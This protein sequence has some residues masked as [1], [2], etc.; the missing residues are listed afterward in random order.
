MSME[1]YERFLNL[2]AHYRPVCLE[3]S[4]DTAYMH[5][6]CSDRSVLPHPPGTL[7]LVD[8]G[9]GIVL[10]TIPIK[11][12]PRPRMENLRPT[13]GVPVAALG[14]IGGSDVHLNLIRGVPSTRPLSVLQLVARGCRTIPGRE[15]LFE[16]GECAEN[17]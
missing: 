5:H 16:A 17:L 8:L 4:S 3:S 2:D 1:G 12:F 10:L 13:M 15:S 6:K 7:Y 14:R 9:A 11:R